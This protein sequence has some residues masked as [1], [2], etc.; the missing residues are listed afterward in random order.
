MLSSRRI[1]TS[2]SSRFVR[3]SS[4]IVPSHPPKSDVPSYPIESAVT[5][6]PQAPNYPKPWSTSQRPR[7]NA[8]TGPRFEQTAMQ[9]QPQPLSAMQM[10]EEEPIRLSHTRVVS[11]DGGSFLVLAVLCALD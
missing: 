5:D 10:I 6:L 2:S 3:L 7:P 1:L 9:L 4:T 11:C 8:N